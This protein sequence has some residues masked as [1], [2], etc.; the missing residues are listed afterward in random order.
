MQLPRWWTRQPWRWPRLGALHRK[1]IHFVNV[2]RGSPDVGALHTFPASFAGISTPGRRSPRRSPSPQ[3]RPQVDPP[4]TEAPG[5]G[6]F[7]VHLVAPRRR[8]HRHGYGRASEG[9]ST[10]APPGKFTCTV[11]GATTL[12]LLISTVLTLSTA[13]GGVAMQHTGSV[14]RSS[15][16]TMP[17]TVNAVAARARK[18][19]GQ[20][21][22]EP[23][24]P[25]TASPFTTPTDGLRAPSAQ[26]AVMLPTS[27]PPMSLRVRGASPWLWRPA[28]SWIMFTASRAFGQR[29]TV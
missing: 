28:A 24:P 21:M 18:Y 14:G 15:S 17:V 3:R 4:C 9:P 1:A 26:G 13:V 27:S 23:I 22:S 11:A 19:R 5:D 7:A 29:I 16:S 12:N 25:H 10:G 2:A 6:D 8:E 20:L